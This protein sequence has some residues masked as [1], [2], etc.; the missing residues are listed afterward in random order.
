MDKKKGKEERYLDIFSFLL[1]FSLP[2][3]SFS[4]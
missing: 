2:L 4:Y 3:L 1:Y